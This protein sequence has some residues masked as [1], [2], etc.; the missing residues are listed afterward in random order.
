VEPQSYASGAQWRVDV[1]ATFAPD[2][3]IY[4]GFRLNPLGDAKEGM[5]IGLTSLSGTAP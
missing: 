1:P 4:A 5:L 3:V 2:R